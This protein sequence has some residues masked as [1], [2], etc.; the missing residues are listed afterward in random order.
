L[1]KGKQ[2]G[3]AEIGLLFTH[4]YLINKVIKRFIQTKM[5]KHGWLD[6][7]ELF[8]DGGATG[9]LIKSR[10][11]ALSYVCLVGARENF[12]KKVAERGM[13]FTTTEKLKEKFDKHQTCW[14]SDS[15]NGTVSVIPIFCYMVK[16]NSF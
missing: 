12:Y 4:N 3:R 7:F 8:L 10:K 16:R 2:R 6:F 1:C 5:S 15:I 11:V 14:V 9:V 13:Y